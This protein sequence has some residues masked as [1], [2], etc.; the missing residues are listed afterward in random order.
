MTVSRYIAAGVVLFAG[1]AAAGGSA[2][3]LRPAQDRVAPLCRDVATGE[4]CQ[5]RSGDVRVRGS[6]RTAARSAQP[7][8]L[9]EAG[10]C[11]SCRGQTTPQAGRPAT[12]AR[13]QAAPDR[14]PD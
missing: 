11:P 13:P 3:A 1:L 8:P 14:A 10:D 2:A 7:A 5:T 9:A 12:P 4:R 6:G